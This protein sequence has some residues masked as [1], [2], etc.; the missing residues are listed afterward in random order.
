MAGPRSPGRDLVQR[1]DD[2]PGDPRRHKQ[3]NEF[4][5][6]EKNVENG[7]CRHRRDPASAW[8]LF[9]VIVPPETTRRCD[10]R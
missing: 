6:D 7:D 5:D 2:E 1:D 9:R 4:K 8:I 10:R 3:S